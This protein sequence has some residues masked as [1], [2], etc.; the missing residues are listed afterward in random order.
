MVTTNIWSEE[1]GVC[2]CKVSL[3]ADKWPLF[4]QLN[5]LQLKQVEN[6]EVQ[7]PKYRSE[8][9]KAPISV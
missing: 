5:Y 2:G 3:C 8:N 6:A 9:K 1:S 4:L 7:K